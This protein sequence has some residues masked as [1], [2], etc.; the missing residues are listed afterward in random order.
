MEGHEE[1]TSVDGGG[2]EGHVGTVVEAAV[3]GLEVHFGEQD[4]FSWEAGA[5]CDDNV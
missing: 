1:E 4:G 5:E 2:L 3:G